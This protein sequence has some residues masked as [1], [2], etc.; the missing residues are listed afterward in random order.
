MYEAK[1]AGGEPRSTIPSDDSN[2][3]DR[4]ALMAELREAIE[5][6]ALD[7][8][9]QPIVSL[10]SAEAHAVEALV[11]W[12]HPERGMLDRGG[13]RASRRADGD[14]QGA[15]PPGAREGS[16]AAVAVAGLGPGSST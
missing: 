5:E 16:G 10:E 6:G 9:Y 8:W 7:V 2:G 13:V 3:L 11:R 15:Q 14:D 4:L 1:R 12:D